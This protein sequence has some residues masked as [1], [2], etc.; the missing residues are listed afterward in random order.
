[1]PT[2]TC[3]DL[4]DRGDRAARAGDLQELATV[5]AA[6]SSRVGDPLTDR[7]NEL[8]RSCRRGGTRPLRMWPD[9]RTAIIDRLET[10]GT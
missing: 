9:M 3:S 5:A 8:T 1:M 7:L 10:A 4:L 2:T 6:L